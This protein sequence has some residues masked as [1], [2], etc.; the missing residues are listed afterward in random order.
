MRL[1]RTT[2]FVTLLGLTLAVSSGLLAR[3]QQPAVPPAPTPAPAKGAAPPAARG[4]VTIPPM[5]NDLTPQEIASL[6]SAVDGL[7]AKV[8]ALHKQY[9]KGAMADRV[10]DVEVYLDAVRRPLKYNERLWAGRG[11]T[12]SAQAM[13]TLATGTERAAHLAAGRT[14]WMNE[15]GVRG[16]YSR[17]DGAV[18][19]YVLTVPDRYD[20]SAKGPYRLDIFLQGRADQQLE[21]QFMAKSVT[22]Y[23]SKPLGAGADRFMVQPYG[24]FTNANRFAGEVDGLEAIESVQK[25]YPIDPN[26]IVITGF[27]MGGAAAWQYGLHYA[28]RWAA[29]SAGAGFT[30]TEVFLRG[31]LTRQPQNAAQ[32][33]LWHLYDSV[34]YAINAFNVPHVA[35]SGE[36][37]GQKQAADAMTVA[38]KAEGL[39]LDHVIGPNTAHM[40][41]PGARQILQDKL[42]AFA[43]KGR[44]PSP[45]EIRF[46]T[47]TLKYNKMFWI[48]L[49]A[50]DRHWE[51]ARANAKIEG[52]TITLATTNVN[53]MHL[54]FE[55]GLAPFAPGTKPT[56]VIDGARLTLPAVGA[57]K[58]LS[59]GLVK[60]GGAWKLGELGGTALR[61]SHGLQGPIDDAFMEPFV[62]VQP[63]GVALE[64]MMGQWARR[65]SEYAVSEWIHFFRGEPRVKKDTE[66]TDADI[67]AYNLALFGDPSS[68]AV[69]KKIASKLPIAWTKEGV[70]VG[71]D[72][73]PSTHA[74]VF[75][76]PNPLNPKKYVVI[77]S[78]FTFHDQSNNAMQSPKLADWAIV[79]ITKPTN[80]YR[81]LPLFVAAQG[82]FDEA[83]KPMPPVAP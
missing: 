76:F 40:Y 1:M 52:D 22:G 2:A 60:T 3:G 50:L 57:N 11:S 38:M 9:P 62:F 75:I 32:R 30:E 77:N 28:D 74:P 71:A 63:T 27:S 37:D 79:D 82:F 55:A 73:Y 72:T 64:P 46:T 69:Y 18:Q 8:A 54:N 39:T 36:I 20:A 78:G 21:Q 16:F 83:W 70:K 43:L 66:I 7:A 49:D 17:L 53:A 4:P 80:N 58:S 23:T 47:W 67:A 44:N 35:Y 25:A 31:A 24:R 56:L 41:E 12:P 61:K 45:A 13:Q 14:P 42:D 5:G 6:Q 34:D 48:T 51:R 29:F 33:K 81:Y 10:A 26:R 59:A 65:Q 15:S 68:N 19:P